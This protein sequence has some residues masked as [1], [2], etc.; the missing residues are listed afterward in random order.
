[1]EKIYEIILG[2]IQNK[3]MEEAILFLRS[4]GYEF[5]SPREFEHY[6]EAE[7]Y[8]CGNVEE[9]TEKYMG[10]LVRKVRGKIQPDLLFSVRLLGGRRNRLNVNYKFEKFWVMKIKWKVKNAMNFKKMKIH[11]TFP[12][13]LTHKE[14]RDW[15]AEHR[16]LLKN[17]NRVPSEWYLKW[18]PKVNF[19]LPIE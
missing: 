19:L 10:Y 7:G 1:M 16:R 6:V 3:T 5:I 12:D 9:N 18:L 13:E 8:G 17:P 15:R 11:W 2:R 4:L 14:R